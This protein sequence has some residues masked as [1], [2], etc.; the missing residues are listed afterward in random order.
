MWMSNRRYFPLSAGDHANRIDLIFKVHGLEHAENYFK[1]IP[2]QK[3]VYQTYGALLKCYAEEKSIEKAES[4]FNIM[5]QLN[6]LT[7]FPYNILISL[8][9]R[10]GQHEKVESMFTEM[11]EKGIRCDAFTDTILLNVYADSLNIPKMEEVLGRIKKFNAVDFYKYAIAARAYVKVKARVKALDKLKKAEKLIPKKN[12]RYAWGFLVTLYA[13]TGDKDEMY[14]IWNTYKLSLDKA[15]NSMY[16]CM[17]SGLL[18]FDDVEGAEALF[19]EWKSQLTVYDVRIPKLLVSAYREKGLLS[20]A[21]CF[22]NEAVQSGDMISSSIWGQLADGYFEANQIPKAVEMMKAVKAEKTWWKLSHE[23]VNAGLKYFEEEKD[24][25][26]AEEFVSLVQKQSPLSR[27]VYHSLM[28]IYMIAGVPLSG[29]LERMKADG[30]DVDEET[31]RI[32][33]ESS[34]NQ[35]K[36]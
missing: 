2:K 31:D 4:L 13:E 8:Y 6:M 34:Q 14:R 18:K 12:N 21:E 16:M 5:K 30:F 1:T 26:G 11:K 7:S 3:K 22:M 35:A 19:M 20:K 10:T 29:V 33:E 15:S 32:L 27:E 17:I 25:K 36:S 28:R 9:S 23:K 24:V